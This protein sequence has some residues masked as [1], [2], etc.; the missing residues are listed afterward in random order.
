MFDEDSFVFQEHGG[1]HFHHSKRKTVAYFSRSSINPQ[2]N[3]FNKAIGFQIILHLYP[4][5]CFKV[6]TELNM[7]CFILL[8]FLSLAVAT[9]S[10]AATASQALRA[11]RES[12][13]FRLA[14][15]RGR[16][17]D[18][19]VYQKMTCS[20]NVAGVL[21]GGNDCASDSLEKGFMIFPQDSC[22]TIEG[23]S[24]KFSVNGNQIT[25]S[26]WSQNSC[27][28]AAGTSYT[29][30]SEACYGDTLL[31]KVYQ[32]EGIEWDSHGKKSD[33]SDVK[34]FLGG[35]KLVS[36][37]CIPSDDGSAKFVCSSD[38]KSITHK[39][40][41]D[42]ACSKETK[43]EERKD[44]ECF[45]SPAAKTVPFWFRTVFVILAAVVSLH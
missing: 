38:H 11:F 4:Y 1:W 29:I 17:L 35:V 36:G 26:I 3:I 25:H 16:R 34:P 7:K 33:C 40:Y 24:Q 5:L 9:A 32:G 10:P 14:M 43:S 45:A 22:I 39:Q 18:E 6:V 21:V 28:G 19:M 8:S 30:A 2:Q 37:K 23:T 42:T 27:D 12:L 31:L 15:Q 41:S 20:K 44:G 13:E